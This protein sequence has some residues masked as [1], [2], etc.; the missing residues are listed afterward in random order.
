MLKFGLLGKGFGGGA[1]PIPPNTVTH[2]GEPVTHNGVYV[3][4]G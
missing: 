2:N 4:H 3:T 1:A